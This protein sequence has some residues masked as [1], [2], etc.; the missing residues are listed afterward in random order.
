M[1]G[2]VGFIGKKRAAPVLAKNLKKLEYRGYDSA[3]IATLAKGSFHLLRCAGPVAGLR[4]G[5]MLAGT[6]GIGHTRWATHGAPSEENAHPHIYGRFAVVHNGIIENYHALKEEC[7]KRGEAFSSQTDSEVIAH[8]LERYY[9]GELLE[10]LRAVC[11]RLRGSYALAV[12]CANEPETIALAREKSPLIAG[13]S[14]GGTVCAS[15]IPAVA[16]QGAELYAIEDG[17]CAVM[18]KERITFYGMGGGEIDKSPLAFDPETEAPYRCGFPHFMKKEMAE[19]P[20]VLKAARPNLGDFRYEAFYEALCRAEH[21]QIAACGTAYYAGLAAKFAFE[22][23]ARV[24]T[25]VSV[26]SEYRYCDPIVPDGTLMLAISQSG[27]TADTIAAAR[28]AKERGAKV[29]AIVNA[30]SSSLAALA[31]YVIPVRAGREIAVAATKTFNA[32]LA[33]LYSIAASLAEYRKKRG[34]GDVLAQLPGLAE[35]ALA[36]GEGVR[37][38]VPYFVGA[39]SVYFIGRGADYVAALEGCLKLKE[40]SYLPS[41]GYP[42]GELK[43]GTLALV[44]KN[45]P[46]VAVLTSRRLAEKM[47]SAIEEVRARGAKV[48]LITS[49]CEYA[50]AEGVTLSVVVPECGEIFSPAL[51]VIPLQQLAYYVSIARGNNPDK[52]RN[53]AKSVTVE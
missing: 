42:A 36:A 11:A 45:T 51:S 23:L 22:S 40:I 39:S 43:H 31:D 18:K 15:D 38:W 17:E 14:D 47:M 4:G 1:C 46:V 30:E 12:M 10:A 5:G 8:L 50:V 13:Y 44:E 28:L 21:L 34:Y 19:I 52:P 20:A 24:R 7:E 9:M 3:G 35:A 33:A 48:F 49:L 27:E 2:I 6:C 26:A 41:E 32:Q 37:S 29:V 53:L 16:K 25:E